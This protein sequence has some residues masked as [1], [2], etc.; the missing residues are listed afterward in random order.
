MESCSSSIC[1]LPTNQRSVN[2][3]IAPFMTSESNRPYFIAVCTEIICE[4]DPLIIADLYD[5]LQDEL[6]LIDGY[7]NSHEVEFNK[8]LLMPILTQGW[9][10]FRNFYN[11][12]SNPLMSYTYLGNSV[13]QT[14]IF[15]GSTTTNEYP[16]YHRL[17]TSNLRDVTFEV[18][19]PNNYPISSKL[20]NL[21]SFA[22]L[23]N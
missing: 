9:H 20:V 1:E 14:Q 15:N 12:T 18:D 7:V 16:R 2:N 11:F 23:S 10:E 3:S 17:T 21:L 8:I 19:M 22:T 13:F 5:E 6:T 4:L